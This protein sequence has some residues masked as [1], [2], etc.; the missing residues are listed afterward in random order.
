MTKKDIRELLAQGQLRE[1]ALAAL[2][3]AEIC[4]AAETANTLTVLQA[5]LEAHQRQWTTGQIAY[6]EFS[7]LHARVTQG[8]T[9]CLD[10]LPD[11]PK[12]GAAKKPPI[13]EGAFKKRLFWMLIAAKALVFGWTYYLW[14]TGG[15][16]N[17]EALTAF[18]AL[19]P[20]FV[21]YISLMLADYLRAH[22]ENAVLRRRYVSGTLTKVAFWLFPLYA[23]AQM[24]I[25]GRKAQGV[26]SFAQMTMALA[27]VESVLGG[28][29]G[30]IV[31]AF[32]KKEE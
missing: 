11:E 13:E 1:A 24:F 10:E 19:T 15:F 27:L 25:V 14:Q 30:Q 29:V 31:Q 3:Y 6:E 28:Y 8:L 32:F 22:R 7:R 17:E 2:S 12:P 18:S 21:A 23:L 4:G 20:A 26:L 16:Q 5:T 9:G